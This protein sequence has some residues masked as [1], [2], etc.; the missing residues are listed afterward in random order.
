VV[1]AVTGK[2]YVYIK[3][4]SGFG[5]I[6]DTDLANQ[7]LNG[8]RVEGFVGKSSPYRSLPELKAHNTENMTITHGTAVEPTEF[9]TVPATSHVNQYVVFKNVTFDEDVV[10][11]SSTATNATFKLNT[12]DVTLRNSFKFD[13]AFEAD[14]AYDIYGAIATYQATES[15]PIEVQVYYLNSAEAGQEVVTYTVTYDANGASGNVPTDLANYAAGQQVIVAGQGEMTYENHMFTGWKYN[16]TIYQAG[17]KFNMPAENVTF[18]AQWEEIVVTPKKDFSE[19]YWVLVTDA[20]ELADKDYIIVA[21]K[22]YN[23][24]MVSYDYDVRKNNC[25]QT[26]ITKFGNNN[27]FL[28]WKEEIGV[29]QLAKEGENYTFQDVNTE[30]YLYAAGGTSSNHLKASD[31]IPTSAE[32]QKY[33]WTITIADRVA[34]VTANVEGRNTIRYNATEGD[35]GKLFSCYASGQKDIALYKHVTELPTIELNSD[36]NSTVITANAGKTVNVKLNRSFT[37]G[38]GYYTLCVP[39]D[40]AASEIG[41]AYELGTITKHVS[42][43]EGGIN[44]NLNSVSTIKAGVPYLVLPNT[45]TNPVFENVTIVNTEGSNYTV[46]GASVKVTFTGI[47][48]GSGKTNGSTEYYVGEYGYLYNGTVEKLGLRAF[49]TITDEAGNPIKVRARVV[50][51]ENVETGIEDIF[52]T[53]APVKVIEN[54]QL[55]IIRDG[56]KY[57]VQGQKL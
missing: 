29:F 33:V 45:L 28:T 54:G 24:A 23:V 55:I 43:D 17:D 22:D 20:N 49:F 48:N 34:T 26:D 51:G 10:F 21:A 52:S 32:A 35:N 41:T 11:N 19:G 6:Y 5:L 14:K 38:D 40:I 30:Q 47:I 27:C 31:A 57:N 3:D 37:A 39:F 8:D 50:A 12:N 16:G 44:I 53:D 7:L 9:S 25:G 4:E 1:Y 15:D 18:V 56:V 13:V 36:D 42:G 46:T 2:E